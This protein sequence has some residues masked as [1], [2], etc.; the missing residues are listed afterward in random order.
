MKHVITMLNQKWSVVFAFLPG[1]NLLYLLF[2]ILTVHDKHYNAPLWLIG[3]VAAPLCALYL[4]VPDSWNWLVTHLLVS[5][6]VAV[7]MVKSRGG[8]Q[9]SLNSPF[10]KSMIFPLCIA[11][12]FLITAGK[13]FPLVQQQHAVSSE[14]K[15][16]LVAI[17]ESD[18]S[19]WQSLL[20]PEKGTEIMDLEHIQN[21][22]SAEGLVLSEDF[23]V[24]RSTAVFSK[25]RS[26]TEVELQIDIGKEQYRAT[27]TY[28]SDESGNGF[29]DFKMVDEF[30]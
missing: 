6:I 24:D 10:S 19:T 17:A 1:I 12:F 28:L 18:T 13:W 23:S 4:I 27:F 25:D 26:I 30:P 15:K 5:A 14:A 16:A 21:Q 8:Y 29:I 20:H 7:I 3:I 11:A 9:A 22:M 2:R